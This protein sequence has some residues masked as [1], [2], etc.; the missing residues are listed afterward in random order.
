[1]T[2]YTNGVTRW[3]IKC[4]AD[5]WAIRKQKPGGNEEYYGPPYT[6]LDAAKDALK[7]EA[8]KKGWREL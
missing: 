7:A 1:M 5:G 6:S 2:E 3:R 8:E 4:Q